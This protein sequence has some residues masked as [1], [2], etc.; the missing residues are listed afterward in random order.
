MQLCVVIST[1]VEL[2]HDC[3]KGPKRHLI[4]WN[5]KLSYTLKLISSTIPLFLVILDCF[6]L[7]Q[8][9]E[10]KFTKQIAWEGQRRS[11]DL[12]V[13]GQKKY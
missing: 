1:E 10:I 9:P 3:L 8:K 6:G 5:R 11:Q 4:I 7:R 13:G 12:G 2:E